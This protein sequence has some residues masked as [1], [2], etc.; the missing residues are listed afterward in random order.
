MSADERPGPVHLRRAHI[1]DAHDIA[2]VHVRSWQRAYRGVVPEAV[3][4]HL[5]ISARE[6]FWREEIGETSPD[7]RP[8]VA[9][10]SGRVVGFV[11][12]GISRDDDAVDAT[13]EIYAIFVEPEYWRMGIGRLLLEHACRDLRARGFVEATLWVVADNLATHWFYQAVG[14]EPDGGSRAEPTG[15]VEIPEIRFRRR[16]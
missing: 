13:G 11:S 5:D 4:E 2:A 14:W 10:A 9:D 8:W 7:H 12:A 1:E 16:L 3:L 6:G 15:T